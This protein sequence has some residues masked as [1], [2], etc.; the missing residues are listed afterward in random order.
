MGRGRESPRCSIS[1]MS[2]GN[3]SKARL[4][5]RGSSGRGGHIRSRRPKGVVKSRCFTPDAGFAAHPPKL[6]GHI[7]G[8]G[9]ENHAPRNE[10]QLDARLE[11]RPLL[12]VGFL[13]E[14]TGAVSLDSVMKGV[15]GGD[16]SNPPDAI[17]LYTENPHCE[18]T[19]SQGLAV[20]ECGSVTGGIETKRPGEALSGRGWNGR[21]RCLVGPV[22]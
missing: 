13:K 15:L 3:G 10:N 7:A 17:P 6:V 12:P 14:A 1:S 22:H 4:R 21:L 20:F 5:A 19:G 18:K 11:V 9:L 8:C 16:C 2:A